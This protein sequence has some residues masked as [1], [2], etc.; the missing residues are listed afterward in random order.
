MTTPNETTETAKTPATK[1]AARPKL[2]RVNWKDRYEELE[3]VHDETVELQEPLL[4]AVE[5]WHGEQHDGAYRHC[6]HPA[7]DAANDIAY[8]TTDE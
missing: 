2:P 6:P 7:C 3:A 4:R 5:I 1:S 8:T